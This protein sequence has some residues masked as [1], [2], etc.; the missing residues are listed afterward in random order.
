MILSTLSYKTKADDAKKTTTLTR[1]KK[2]QLRPKR[3]LPTRLRAAFLTGFLLSAPL[4]VTLYLTWLVVTF[5]DDQVFRLVPQA[6]HAMVQLPFPGLGLLV[7][8]VALTLFGALATGLLGRFFLR[9]SERIIQHMPVVRGIY[10]AIKQ[11][12][13]T[14]FGGGSE[15][16]RQV[17]L[18]EYPRKGLW[19]IVF[20]SNRAK[21]PINKFV[22]DDSICVFLPTTPNPTS[23]FLL[24]VPR[25]DVTLLDIS[26]EDAFKLVVSGGTAFPETTAHKNLR[27]L[28]RL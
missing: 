11:I 12:F 3:T 2:A 28:E 16:F 19:A 25:Q 9:T 24:F 15:A 13:S 1:K 14:V 5:V 26:V 20:I 10:K 6:Y 4:G 22:G 7:V 27:R 18:L 8:I 21:A 23:G 17:G